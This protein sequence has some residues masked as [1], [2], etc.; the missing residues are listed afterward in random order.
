ME[1][2]KEFY[3]SPSTLCHSVS[4]LPPVRG[5]ALAAGQAAPAQSGDNVPERSLQVGWAGSSSQ[6]APAPPSFVALRAEQ[7][8]QGRPWAVLCPAEPLR[9][10]DRTAKSCHPSPGAPAAPGWDRQFLGRK[11]L[12][13]VRSVS[14]KSICVVQ[15][16]GGDPIPVQQ[17]QRSRCCRGGCRSGSCW[18]TRALH[19]SSSPRP[20]QEPL[21]EDG[22]QIY[23]GWRMEGDPDP[24]P[25]SPGLLGIGLFAWGWC[26]QDHL[27]PESPL[28]AAG[29]HQ[30]QL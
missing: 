21:S 30:G 9:Q 11:I 24:A 22:K 20:W 6:Q 27:A 25:G 4:A 1:G 26:S 7:E 5:Q 23:Q 10:L 17:W 29:T 18:R 2:C 28:S 8:G 19:C 3:L 15:R 13:H 12:F 14:L 16:Q